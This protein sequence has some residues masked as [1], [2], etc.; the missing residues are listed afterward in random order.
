MPL[1]K[2]DIPFLLHQLQIVSWL[3]LGLCVQFSFLVLAFCLVWL[4]YMLSYSLCIQTVTACIFLLTGK[5]KKKKG[6]HDVPRLNQDEINDLNTSITPSEIEVA[7]KNNRPITPSELEV[8]IKNLQ[9][10][11]LGDR[12]CNAGFY[13]TFKEQTW[14]L[15]KLLCKKKGIS[16]NSFLRPQ[17]FRLLNHTKIQQRK[18]ITEQF[19]LWTQMKISQ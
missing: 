19:P 7:V 5:P 1:K 8:V 9:T 11:S 12:W 2:T 3:G 17:L 4:L 10:K 18:R 15:L 6:M 16:P 13:Q 14:T